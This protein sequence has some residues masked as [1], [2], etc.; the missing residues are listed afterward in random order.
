MNKKNNEI[1]KKNLKYRVEK[2]IKDCLFLSS[3]P[4]M[5]LWFF[6]FFNIFC[7]VIPFWEFF[8]EYWIVLIIAF[9]LSIFIFSVLFYNHTKRKWIYEHIKY[10]TIIIKKTEIIKFVPRIKN[11]FSKE[12]RK[13]DFTL[14]F[15]TS[16]WEREYKSIKY[17]A[18]EIWFIWDEFDINLYFVQKHKNWFK[19]RWKKFFIWDKVDVYIDPK[20]KR[21]Y[22][23]NTDY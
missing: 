4:F 11:F 18:W 3:I 10:G 8:T 15:L 16:D 1:F 2:W 22:I 21:N 5:M 6:L 20:H 17:S 7:R 14:Y 12:H 19:L 9:W 23:L 13:E